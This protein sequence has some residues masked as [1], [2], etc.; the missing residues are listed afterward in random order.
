MS[1]L[2]NYDLISICETALVDTIEILEILINGYTFISSKSECSYCLLDFF[3]IP[4]ALKFFDLAVPA[5]CVKAHFWYFSG[6]FNY[7]SIYVS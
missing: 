7:L 2:I 4:C 5:F 6:T 1:H 3:N